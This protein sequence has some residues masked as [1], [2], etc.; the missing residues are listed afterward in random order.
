MYVEEARHF[1]ACVRGEA[2]PKCDGWDGLKT[3]K[4]IEAARRS[5]VEQRWVKV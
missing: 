5:A 2:T 1:V 3:M 4:V